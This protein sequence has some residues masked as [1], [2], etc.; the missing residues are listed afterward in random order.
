[1]INLQNVSPAI[2]ALVKTLMTQRNDAYDAVAIGHANAADLEAKIKDS[3]EQI[4]QLKKDLSV[5]AIAKES[6]QDEDEGTA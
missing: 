1:M 2:E 3:A 6:A 4:E 5:A